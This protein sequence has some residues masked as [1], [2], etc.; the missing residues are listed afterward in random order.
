MATIRSL[1]HSSN[2]DDHEA[3]N[4]CQVESAIVRADGVLSIR[5]FFDWKPPMPNGVPYGYEIGLEERSW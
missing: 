5:A 2:D 1:P 4:G 3:E